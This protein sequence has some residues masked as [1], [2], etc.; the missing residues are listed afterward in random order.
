MHSS[1]SR[2]CLLLSLWGFGVWRL[3][4]RGAHKSV[5]ECI[6][7]EMSVRVRETDTDNGLLS[8]GSINIMIFLKNLL[9]FL[10]FLGEAHN[11]YLLVCKAL[12]L[13]YFGFYFGILFSLNLSEMLYYRGNG[14]LK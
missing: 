4:V 5:S 13:P 9:L 2:L 10:Y 14:A 7:I 6:C 12:N 3:H 11:L 8:C 1:A